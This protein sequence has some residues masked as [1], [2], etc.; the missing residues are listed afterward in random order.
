MQN[1]MFQSSIGR[2]VLHR[3]AYVGFPT[4]FSRS[5][6]QGVAGQNRNSADSRAFYPASFCAIGL[7]QFDTV[8]VMQFIIDFCARLSHIA[9]SLAHR[10]ALS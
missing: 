2:R 6:L 7:R 10:G 1:G 3:G 9:P 4:S 8:H 5:E